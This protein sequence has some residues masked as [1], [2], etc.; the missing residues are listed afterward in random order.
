MTTTRDDAGEHEAS[1]NG[2]SVC[3]SN[4][5][6]PTISSEALGDFAALLPASKPEVNTRHLRYGPDSSDS[7]R[8]RCKGQ[9]WTALVGTAVLLA[10][11]LLIWQALRLG[12]VS[13]VNSRKLLTLLETLLIYSGLAHL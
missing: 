11:V 12:L 6:G 13:D 9:G 3:T 4:D 7:A 1:L 8:S 5:H 2:E 10:V